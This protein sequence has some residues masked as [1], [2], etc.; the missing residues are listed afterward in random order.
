MFVN[1]HPVPNGTN[2]KIIERYITQMQGRNRAKKRCNNKLLGRNYTDG[3]EK[4]PLHKKKEKIVPLWL[5]TKKG[6]FLT[7]HPV[8]L[9]TQ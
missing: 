6:M 1:S 5:R 8:L 9:P 4:L 3:R 2:N 7:S